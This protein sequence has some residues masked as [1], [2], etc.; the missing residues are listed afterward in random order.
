[1]KILLKN[2]PLQSTSKTMTAMLSVQRIPMPPQI[3]EIFRSRG[4]PPEPHPFEQ[5]C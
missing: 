2:Y 4:P 5:Q 3:I 1:M